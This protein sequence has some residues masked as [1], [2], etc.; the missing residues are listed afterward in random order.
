MSMF[1]FSKENLWNDKKGLFHVLV[2][3]IG[4]YGLLC[5]VYSDIITQN[6]NDCVLLPYKSI[7]GNEIERSIEELT[8][9]AKKEQ[10]Q[11][12]LYIFVLDISGSL[13]KINIKGTLKAKYEEDVKYVNDR[14]RGHKIDENGEP[15]AIDIAKMK[16]Y[17]LLL[18][19]EKK[20]EEC[21]IEDEFAIWTLG[22]EGNLIFPNDGSEKIK[23]SKKS[24]MNAIQEIDK[25][26]KFTRNTDFTSL[27]RRII[28][29]YQ[30]DFRKGQKSIF[31]SPFIVITIL[32]DLIH[33]VENKYKKR[34]K[35][36]EK[37][38]DNLENK[39]QEI[40]DCRTMVNL[41]ALS[42]KGLDVQKTIFPLFLDSNV[43]WFRLNRFLVGE[44][45]KDKFL[46]TV[47]T[48]E[49]NIRFFYTN[50][51]YISNSSFVIK[52]LSNENVIK[53]D[54]PEEIHYP[55]NAKLSVFCQKLNAKGEEL[56]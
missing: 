4:L 12:N 2:I 46:F 42:Y 13:E 3:I 25:K 16:L 55:Q 8:K 23:I 38:W 43:D 47:R 53:I 18:E 36:I 39:I 35:E 34:V 44:G 29:Q 26:D 19:L 15:G 10:K 31:D 1:R 49:S 11:N 22:D 40:S 14:I 17:I 32:S 41:I 20:N 50:S 5:T 51:N 45:K 9:N 48:S 21:D 37:D 24:I 7:L 33:D 27:F 30:K 56:N 6:R 28:I 52:S 54:L